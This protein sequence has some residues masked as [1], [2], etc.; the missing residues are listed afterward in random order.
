MIIIIDYGLGN[1]GSMYN[2]LKRL[3]CQ[4]MI[5]SDPAI[6][7]KA[8]RLILPGV[9]A[10]DSGMRNLE[11]RGLLPIINTRVLED[12]IPI[13]GVCLGMQLMTQ[14]SEEGVLPGLCWLDAAT[15]RFKFDTTKE[16]EKVP[17]MGWSRIRLCQDHWLFKDFDS[18]SRFYFAHSYHVKCSD[19][20][21]VTAVASYG[22]EFPAI[23]G[24]DNITGVQFHPE[25]SHR[26]GMV[27]LR[28]FTEYS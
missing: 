26:Y 24:K 7:N 20:A 4:A 8:D 12:K 10:F 11:E 27:L 6:I 21:N 23:I 18:E 2:M 9:G 14:H 1:L 3:G 16:G 22:Y 13:L 25:K 5:S 19:I 28:N 15:V 17:H